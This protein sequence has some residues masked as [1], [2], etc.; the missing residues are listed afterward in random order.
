MIGIIGGMVFDP[1]NK[2]NGKVKDIWIK[3]GK[4]VSREE[5]NQDKVQIIDAVGQVVMPG[6]VDIHSHI[7]GPKVNAGR[8]LCPE[9]SRR[10][11]RS[12]TGSF[13]SGSG[14][15][16]P[17]TSLTGYLYSEMGYT[18]V[19]EAAAAPL[20][21]RHTHEELED[22]PNID[23]GAF[24]TMGN[25]HFIMKCIRDGEMEKAR[26]YVGWLLGAGKGFAI[27][28]VN[29]GGVENWKYGKNVQTLD[30]EVIGFGVTPRQILKTLASISQELKLP[31]PVHV[32]GLRLGQSGSADITM[33][34][35]E[36][37]E[38]L[39]AHF[40]HL[41]FMSYSGKRGGFPRSGAVKVAQTVNENPNITID[42]GQIIFGP[43]TTM[44][45]DGPVQ[46][47]LS[48]KLGAKWVNDDLESESG[49]GLVP[50]VY[51][52]S[53]PLHAIMWLTGLEIFLL[54]NDPWRVFLTTDHPNAGP[55]LGY[56]E[57]IRLL[58]DKDFR[59]EEF[60]K[61]PKKAKKGSLLPE[62]NR[63]YSLYEIAIITRA[64]PARRLGLKNKGHLGI[65]ADA[66]I[67]VYSRAE[68]KE[69]MFAHPSRV[70]KDGNIVVI[71]G[72]LVKEQ[73]GRTIYVSP[74]YDKNI[75]KYL[76][77]HFKESYTI[78]FNNYYIQAEHLGV[79]EKLNCI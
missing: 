78:S 30:D 48:Q 70:L 18:T 26:D 31:H 54:I 11:L 47:N 12:R 17:S 1:L 58:M 27:K 69:E 63:E 74:D 56:P 23:K 40:C 7:A 22:I 71:D 72:Q 16:V 5:I 65:G 39:N 32:H 62:L 25:N 57:V 61:I 44:T 15:T 34:T 53:N 29:P 67:T 10:L 6:G 46:Y 45:S 49:G 28:I 68:N 24:L 55:F 59:A 79:S 36:L 14:Y 8:K 3:D 37:M 64:G 77:E 41:H 60:E 43:A 38:E 2:I 52:R 75:E 51:K 21:A 33:E 13:R 20:V 76:R 50:L 9:D 73:K 35:M 66:D 4:I 19:M 42:V